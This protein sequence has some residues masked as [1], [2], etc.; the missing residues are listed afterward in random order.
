MEAKH[1][2]LINIQYRQFQGN[3]KT[4]LEHAKMEISLARRSRG[5]SQV[6]HRFGD[7]LENIV[8]LGVKHSER[9]VCPIDLN[10]EVMPIVRCKRS[11]EEHIECVVANFEAVCVCG[12]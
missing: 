10:C 5:S 2:G 1:I 6:W 4:H 11:Q 3:R 9:P 7:S 12:W 8:I